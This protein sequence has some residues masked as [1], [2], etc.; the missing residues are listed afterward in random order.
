MR[1]SC[2]VNRML[3]LVKIASLCFEPYSQRFHANAIKLMVE[4]LSVRVQMICVHAVARKE[5]RFT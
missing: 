4:E 1:S 3:W 5:L 2:G